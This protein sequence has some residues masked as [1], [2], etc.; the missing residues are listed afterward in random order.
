M[1]VWMHASTSSMNQ[2]PLTRT[3]PLL[4]L[5]FARVPIR[6]RVRLPTEDWATLTAM[7]IERAG[8]MYDDYTWVWICVACVY[9]CVCM[10][11]CVY[12]CRCACEHVRLGVGVCVAFMFHTYP[13]SALGS[14]TIHIQ[15]NNNAS[16]CFTL[17][18]SRHMR[19]ASLK[20]PFFVLCET[21]NSE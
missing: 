13:V 21:T 4:P 6:P 10:H 11:A 18:T 9:V 7:L 20:C 8:K 2:R 16:M 5:F 3:V 12:V 1:C 17:C 15:R 19:D 14:F